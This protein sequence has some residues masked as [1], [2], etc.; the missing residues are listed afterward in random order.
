VQNNSGLSLKDLGYIVAVAEELNFH[1]AAERCCVTQ[2]TLSVQLKKCEHYLGL[3]IFE[4]DKHHV[5]VTPIGA[6]VV[7][8]ARLALKAAH[9]IKQLSLRCSAAPSRIANRDSEDQSPP[10]GRG[11]RLDLDRSFYEEQ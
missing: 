10:S 1:R 5:G 6:E 4:R 8:Y 9:A 11:L 3:S 2:S 7:S